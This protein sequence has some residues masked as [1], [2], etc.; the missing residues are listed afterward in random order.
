MANVTGRIDELQ[1]KVKTEL[2]TFL[3]N[4]GILLSLRDAL[5]AL[6]KTRPEVY[7]RLKPSYDAL[8]ARQSTI[9]K[10]AM[11]W[12]SRIAELKTTILSNPD[13]SGALS[14]GAI[15]PAVFSADFWSKVTSYTNQALP[16][17][18]EGLGLSSIL[19]TQNGDVALLKKSVEQGVV[20]VPTGKTAI[21]SQG[22]LWAY[23]LIGL[24]MAYLIATGKKKAR[25]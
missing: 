18:N 19:V 20:L 9:E 14:S 15:S 7:A 11:D 12:M 25:A 1:A 8:Y 16:L 17:I 21:I 10:R 2:A 24:G 13:I 4:Q 3:A 22:L 6:K 5:D 23:G